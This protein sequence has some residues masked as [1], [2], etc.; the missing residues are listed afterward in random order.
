M[1]IDF[2]PEDIKIRDIDRVDVS[3]ID[4]WNRYKETDNVARSWSFSDITE[5]KYFIYKIGG[6]NP[7]LPDEVGPIFPY[8]LNAHTNYIVKASVSGAKSYPCWNLDVNSLPPNTKSAK[9]KK[10][11]IGCH[12]LTALAFVKPNYSNQQIVAHQNEG[13]VENH[14]LWYNHDNLKWST[15]RDNIASRFRLSTGGLVS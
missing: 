13:E 6:K 7:Y 12:V 5:G 1:Q 2:W 10:V 4:D 9:A 15:Q 8:L 11:L 14:R 3:T